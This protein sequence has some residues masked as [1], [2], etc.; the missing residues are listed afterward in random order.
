M[1]EANFQALNDDVKQLVSDAQALFVAAAELTGE[2][3]E[4]ARKR[5]MQLLDIAVAKAQSAQQSAVQ[6]S[7]QAVSTVD[8]SVK[9][10]PWTAVM[11]AAAAGLLL[12]IYINRK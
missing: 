5:G 6:A 12:G 11:I 1:L 10:N 9:D 3:A 2:K 8:T 4:D 7:K